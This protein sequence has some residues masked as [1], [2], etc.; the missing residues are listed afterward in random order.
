MQLFW[1]LIIG[2]FIGWLAHFLLVG[3]KS[4]IKMDVAAGIAGSV[5]CGLIA[6]SL[7]IPEDL[8]TIAIVDIVLGSV[9]AAMG[10]FL[11]RAARS[12]RRR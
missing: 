2:G 7:K 12:Q 8:P 1:F 11:V 9:G 3:G 6:M 10:V 4:K 5:S